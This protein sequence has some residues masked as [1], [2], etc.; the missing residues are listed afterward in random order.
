MSLWA[1]RGE[2]ITAL[3]WNQ[4]ASGCKANSLMAGKGIVI[5]KLPSSTVISALTQPY[6]FLHPWKVS[7]EEGNFTVR[8][9]TINGKYVPYESEK[10]KENGP[11][12]EGVSEPQKLEDG[13]FNAKKRCWICIETE[14]KGNV[15]TKAKYVQV[16]DIQEGDTQTEG[17]EN[18]AARTY[19][20]TLAK[21]SRYPLAMIVNNDGEYVVHQIAYFNLLYKISD[22]KHYFVPA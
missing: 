12:E 21:G 16:A 8:D 13:L 7:V 15:M 17:K 4:L 14:V 2:P 10:D 11:S 9:G 6:P 22:T 18:V 19:Y 3:K 20:P 1:K 5:T